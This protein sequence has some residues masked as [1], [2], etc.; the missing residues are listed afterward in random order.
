MLLA[1]ASFGLSE[2]ILRMTARSADCSFAQIVALRRTV[3]KRQF[4][5]PLTKGG[6]GAGHREMLALF[7]RATREPLHLELRI[8]QRRRRDSS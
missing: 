8:L 5:A 7:A 3:S 6:L 2:G 4:S 1:C